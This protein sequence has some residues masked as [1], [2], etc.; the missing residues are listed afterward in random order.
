VKPFPRLQWYLYPKLIGTGLR[1]EQPYQERLF[2]VG[3]Q[4]ERRLHEQDIKWWDVQ[5]EEY[6]GLPKV[7]DFPGIWEQETVR[8]GGA[9]A[10]E[11][12]PFWLITSRS[13]QYAWG[14]NVGILLMNEVS[15][16]RLRDSHTHVADNPGQPVGFLTLNVDA[17]RFVGPTNGNFLHCVGVFLGGHQF[18]GDLRDD[19]F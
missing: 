10:L 6:G 8:Q 4:L 3:K 2:R 13:M 12:Y 19:Q 15:G 16:N 7:M 1:F 18:V 11:T 17:V 14:S 5:L 9:G